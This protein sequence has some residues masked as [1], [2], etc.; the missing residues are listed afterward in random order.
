[1]QEKVAIATQYLV[2]KQAKEH[3]LDISKLTVSKS[4]IIEIIE[5]YTR[6]S[7]VRELERQIATVCRKIA[8]NIVVKSNGD[9]SKMVHDKKVVVTPKKVREMLG[10]RIFSEK[11]D[12]TEGAVGK[13]V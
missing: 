13:V 6:E 2:P 3:G 11:D 4:A 7:G 12:N 10:V 1:M 9:T 5:G 8:Y